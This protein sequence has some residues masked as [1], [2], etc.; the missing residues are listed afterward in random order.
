MKILVC[1]GR[2][3]NDRPL[4]FQVLNNLKPRPTCIVTGDSSGADHHAEAWAHH[5][6]DWSVTSKAYPADWA[7]YGASAG[8]KRN[9]YML[10]DNPDIA[11]VV[12]FPGG[13][14]TA[15]MVRRAQ[16]RNIPVWQP[17]AGINLIVGSKG[18]NN[19]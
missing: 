6:K 7:R 17:V 13:R 10:D 9:Q 18:I 15:D 19:G 2:N 4:I 5:N 1:G 3:F 14:G 11:R 16:A 8:P 12:A